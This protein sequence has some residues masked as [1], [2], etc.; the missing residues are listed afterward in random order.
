M[1]FFLL[2]KLL[3]FSALQLNLLWIPSCK[4]IN[5]IGQVTSNKQHS[6]L[7][8]SAMKICVNTVSSSF[9]YFMMDISLHYYLQVLFPT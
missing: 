7:C 2:S 9:S 1:F 5:L 3:E 4:T 6:T 8:I